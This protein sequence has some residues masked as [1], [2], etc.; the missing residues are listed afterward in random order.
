MRILA[1][2]RGISASFSVA[3]KRSSM[4]LVLSMTIAFNRVR[5][6]AWDFTMRLRRLFF[7]IELFLAILVSWQSAFEKPLRLSLPER[8]VECV[9]QSARLRVGAGVRADGDV[10]APDVDRLVVVDLREN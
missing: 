1:E 8:E 6:P 4:D 10:H 7:S 5:R 3:A 2:L 9:E